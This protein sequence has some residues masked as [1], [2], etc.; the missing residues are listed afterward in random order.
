MASQTAVDDED[1]QDDLGFRYSAPPP[2]SLSRNVN[3]GGRLAVPTAKTTRSP[4]PGLARNF[5]EDIPSVRSTSA[6]RSSISHLS[7]P[8]APP[9]TTLRTATSMPPLDPPTQRGKRFSSDTLRFNTKDSGDQREASGLRDELDILQEENENI[10]V[11]LRLEEERCKEA[12]TRVR[13]LEKQVMDTSFQYNVHYFCLSFSLP[14]KIFS[15]KQFG[16]VMCFR[17]V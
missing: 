6:G 12:E 4:S 5:L 16:R 15:Q 9:K 8:V 11:K 1:D 14:W 2:I 10:L 13:E 3:N 7:L 17:F